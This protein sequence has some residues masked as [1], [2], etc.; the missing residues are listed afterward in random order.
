MTQVYQKQENPQPVSDV[1]QSSHKKQS[2]M[3][4]R[5]FMALFGLGCL[6]TLSINLLLDPLW[7]FGGNRLQGKNYSFNERLTKANLYAQN[8][9]QYDCIIFGSSRTTLLHQELVEGSNCF[10]FAFGAGRVEEFVAYANWIAE[11]GRVPDKV[12]IAVEHENVKRF[13]DNMNPEINTPSFVLEGKNPPPFLQPYLSLSSLKLSLKTL[14]TESPEPRLYDKKFN[15]IVVENPPAYKPEVE[16]TAVA[17]RSDTV[18]EYEALMAV[19]PD[20][21]FIGYVPP[22][23]PWF[24]AS[25]SE[26]EINT[27]LDAAH[28]IA[29]EM[30]AF[31]DFSI[32][33]NITL[34]TENTYDGSHFNL[35]VNAMIADSINS[36][37]PTFGMRVD[38]M[39][40]NEYFQKHRDALVQ[41]ESDYLTGG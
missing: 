7:Y 32:P 22:L 16:K 8:P 23:S 21:E 6:A 20:A 37:S 17:I 4:V 19:F 30:E 29:G 33:S 28:A 31:Y 38:G 24:L 5:G 36:Q 41:F 40:E 1:I 11:V 35:E 25:K 12:I 9:Q 2:R 34:D 10:N 15:G 3:F 39:S 27:F 26:T 14:F 13:G 18:Q